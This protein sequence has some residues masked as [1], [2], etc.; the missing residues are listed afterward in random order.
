M[1]Q[2]R[3]AVLAAAAVAVVT[4]VHHVYGAILYG[5]PERYHAVFIAAAAFALIVAGE[6]ATVARADRRPGAW[7]R[8]VSIGVNA[9]VMV[10]LF[11]VIEGGYNHVLK[12]ALHLGGASEQVMAWLYRAALYETPND[13]IFEATGI[14]HVVP[15]AF[16]AFFLRGALMR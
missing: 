8:R 12:V 4:T 7:G 9:V 11:G 1:S 13:L 16:A 15:A 5:T 6:A 2:A 10:L 14:L 3:K